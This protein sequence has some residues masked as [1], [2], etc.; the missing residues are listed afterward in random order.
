M[1]C[2]VELVGF[3]DL[4]EHAAVRRNGGREGAVERS[5]VFPLP[6]VA[7]GLPALQTQI[8]PPRGDA[9]GLHAAV[10][11][12]DGERTVVERTRPD[13]EHTVLRLAPCGLAERI[14]IDVE[15]L[16]VGEK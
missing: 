1:T 6:E 4:D 15:D 14:L 10:E 5:E 13:L 3:A 7:D 2:L 11:E 12:P 8:R 16:V 9:S